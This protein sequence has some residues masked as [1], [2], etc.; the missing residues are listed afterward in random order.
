MPG[1]EPWECCLD[2]VTAQ[3]KNVSSAASSPATTLE[4]MAPISA[5]PATIP[6]PRL[7]FFTP[8]TSLKK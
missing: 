8:S 4:M 2:T 1:G 7:A 3:D 5:A 6:V